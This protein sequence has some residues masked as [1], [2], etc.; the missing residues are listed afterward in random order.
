MCTSQSDI[1]NRLFY[2]QTKYYASFKRNTE[3]KKVTSVFI[4]TLCMYVSV[5][6]TAY[7]V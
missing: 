5:I 1:G 2:F 4:H 7:T 3:V 6:A